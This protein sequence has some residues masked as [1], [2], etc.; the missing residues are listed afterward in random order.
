[1]RKDV[2]PSLVTGEYWCCIIGPADLSTK[3]GGM[4]SPFRAAVKNV[5]QEYFPRVNF[6]CWSGWGISEEVK[7]KILK[8]WCRRPQCSVR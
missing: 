4:D 8:D 2:I 6:S 7:D 1:M 5:F 3:S